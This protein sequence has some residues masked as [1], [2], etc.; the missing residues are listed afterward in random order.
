MQL[1]GGPGDCHPPSPASGML[2]MK[3][4]E[5]QDEAMGA[6]PSPAMLGWEKIHGADPLHLQPALAM[7]KQ[8]PSS[9]SSSHIQHLQRPAQHRGVTSA[10]ATILNPFGAWGSHSGHIPSILL[11]LPGR[12]VQSLGRGKR[13]RQHHGRTAAGPVRA[14]PACP[15][16]GASGSSPRA[17]SHPASGPAG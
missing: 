8:D 12:F 6:A 5:R 9:S 11:S 16:Q 10:T 7:S 4:W 13:E 2:Q 17:A 15:Q 3:P 1:A 14:D